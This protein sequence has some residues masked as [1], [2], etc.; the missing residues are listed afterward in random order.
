MT[1]LDLRRS[2]IAIRNLFVASSDVI[3]ASI[4]QPTIRFEQQPLT[5][6]R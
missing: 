3:L 5:A 6:R 4:A 1:W 2:A